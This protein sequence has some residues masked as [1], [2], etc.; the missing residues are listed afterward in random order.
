MQQKLTQSLPQIHFGSLLCL[1]LCMWILFSLDKNIFLGIE[2][3]NDLLRIA[4]RIWV[5]VVGSVLAYSWAPEPLCWITGL[6]LI[7]G[8]CISSLPQWPAWLLVFSKAFFSRIFRRQLHFHGL[9]WWH[10]C[11]IGILAPAKLAWDGELTKNTAVAWCQ[12]IYGASQPA[13]CR[14][15]NTASWGCVILALPLG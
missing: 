10:M 9:H 1:F 14:V 7:A 15:N 12:Q 8:C 6:G 13:G 4:R 2:R 11:L 5:P 3:L